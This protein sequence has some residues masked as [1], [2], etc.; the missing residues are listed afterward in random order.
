MSK[1]TVFVQRR[2]KTDGFQ[3]VR[4]KEKQ[5]EAGVKGTAETEPRLHVRKPWE[6]MGDQ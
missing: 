1:K 5:R 3:D 2:G 6:I 4:S